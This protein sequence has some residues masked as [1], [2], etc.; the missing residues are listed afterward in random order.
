MRSCII[1]CGS[2]G[3]CGVTQPLWSRLATL[4]LCSCSCRSPLPRCLQPRGRLQLG[5]VSCLFSRL[6]QG[7]GSRC[8]GNLPVLVKENKTEARGII[9]RRV[10]T[11]PNLE[12]INDNQYATPQVVQAWTKYVGQ[13]GVAG[14]NGYYSRGQISRCPRPPVPADNLV[15]KHRK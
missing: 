13:I 15:V 7:L 4:E 2:L 11:V 12:E 3:L 6:G 1:R 10:A 5:V 9:S 8:C 14:R